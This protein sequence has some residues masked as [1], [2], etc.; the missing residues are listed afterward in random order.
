MVSWSH[1]TV[2]SCCRILSSGLQ[3]EPSATDSISLD[4]DNAIADVVLGECRKNLAK[5]LAHVRLAPFAVAEQD[6]AWS[7][8]LRDCKQ[9]RV[10]E[11]RG[12]DRSRFKQGAGDNRCVW[13]A[14][15]AESGGV[16]RIVPAMLKPLHQLRRQRHVDQEL[17]SAGSAGASATVSSSARK[18][19]YRSASSMSSSSK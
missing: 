18:A 16:H 15:E 2:D 14:V 6:E 7:G 4:D 12:Y 1:C 11:V 5:S 9:A 10:V 19:P 17:H 8:G 13:R 3:R